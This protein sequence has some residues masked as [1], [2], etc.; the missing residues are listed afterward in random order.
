MSG[1]GKTMIC[2]K[3]AL[4]KFAF[5]LLVVAATGCNLREGTPVGPEQAAQLGQQ[6]RV[7]PANDLGR[8]RYTSVG[9][10]DASACKFA[11]WDDTPT[12]DGV[13]NQLRYKASEMSANAITTVRCESGTGEAFCWS[14]VACTAEAI[15]VGN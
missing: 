13:T 8:I 15:E 6:V 10:I 7:Y 2:Y 11:F 5:G 4:Y 14:R 9:P 12:E 3:S 1:G